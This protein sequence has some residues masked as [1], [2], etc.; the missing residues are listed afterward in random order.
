MSDTPFAMNTNTTDSVGS[1]V[2]TAGK[3]DLAHVNWLQDQINNHQVEMPLML[4]TAFEQFGTKITQARTDLLD[5]RVAIGKAL[6]NGSIATAMNEVHLKDS[7]S[8]HTTNSS[9][10]FP[11]DAPPATPPVTS[12]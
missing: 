1:Q 4:Y 10:A 11:P 7:F 6:Q 3:Q 9:D 5:N 12:P 2:E 8:S